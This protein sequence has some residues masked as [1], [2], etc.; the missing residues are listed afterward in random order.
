MSQM[1][2]VTDN[3]KH[4]VP[5]VNTGNIISANT[6]K[7]DTLGSTAIALALLATLV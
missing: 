7:Q 4:P 2:V 1:S 6:M 3:R 5:I